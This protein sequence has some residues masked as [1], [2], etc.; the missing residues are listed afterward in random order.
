MTTTDLKL[1]IRKAIDS[2]PESVLV[3]ILEYLKQI[4][5]TPGEKIDLSQ[6]LRL[7]LREDKEL[8]QRLAL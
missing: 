6:H 2:V 5:I 1:E 3:D 4:Q 8:L 7:I